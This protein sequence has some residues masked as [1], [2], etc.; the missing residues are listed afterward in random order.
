MSYGGSNIFQG[1]S[2]NYCKLYVP[3]GK[4]EDYQFTAPWSDFL[5]ILEEGG[6]GGS[7]P[8]Y[9]DVNGDGHVNSVDVAIIYNILLGNDKGETHNQ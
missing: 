9:G 7:T 8:V 4:V 1:V 3:A 6:G 5:N 2:T